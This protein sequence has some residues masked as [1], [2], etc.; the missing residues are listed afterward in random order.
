MLILILIL[1]SICGAPKELVFDCKA[2]PRTKA[3]K[4]KLENLSLTLM[5]GLDFYFD[6]AVA[7]VLWSWC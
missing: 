3:L 7:C 6:V 5:F 1:I 2:H 4:C